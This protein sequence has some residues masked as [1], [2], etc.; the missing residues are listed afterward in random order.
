M[1]RKRCV[2]VG[3]E[4]CLHPED[5]KKKGR[6]SSPLGHALWGQVLRNLKEPMRRDVTNHRWD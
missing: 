2:Q 1:Q 5:G 4:Q 6:G 3:L